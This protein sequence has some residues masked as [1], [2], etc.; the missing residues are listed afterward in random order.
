MKQRKISILNQIVLGWVIGFMIAQPMFAQFGLPQPVWV[1]GD[2]SPT[3]LAQL[4]Q[5]VQ[6]TFVQTSIAFQ[7]IAQ[8]GLQTTVAVESTTSR[9]QTYLEY[10]ETA[11]RWLDTVTHYSNVVISNVR[12]FTTL[13]GIMGFVEKELGLSTDTL[14]ALAD[15]G[16]LIRSMYAL[17]NQFLSLI[18]T[19]LDMIQNLESRARN[20]IFNPT[21]DLQ[22][23]ENYLQNSIGRSAAATVA[24]REKLA[25]Y[26]NE[27]ELWTH[28]LLQIRAEIAEKEKKLKKIQD[29]MEIEGNLSQEARETG[30]DVDGNPTTAGSG[31]VSLSGD[32]ILTLTIHAGQLESQIIELK[33]QE[34]DLIDKIKARYD[35]HHAR[36]DNSYYTA[37]RWKNTL[38]GWQL[39]SAA[40]KQEIANI[41]DNYGSGGEVTADTPTPTP[42]QP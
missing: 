18:F 3:S 21:A 5:Q 7:Q 10:I 12:R 8:T 35:E 14:K 20:G 9:I 23:L 24:T 11:K 30:A 1:I 19:R 27:L 36:F 6:Q 31:R 40:K 28:Q 29:E 17:K 25:E 41:I 26:D 42:I 34:K 22:D 39:F 13:K 2:S 37:K 33:K 32:K 15:V 16:Q 38:D 4:E